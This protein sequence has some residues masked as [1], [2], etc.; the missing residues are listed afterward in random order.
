MDSRCVTGTSHRTGSQWPLR[1]AAPS[2]LIFPPQERGQ[3]QQ[4]REEQQQ[5]HQGEAQTQLPPQSSHQAEGEGEEP[6]TSKGQ[7]SGCSREE[8]MCQ[9]PPA[10]TRNL[11]EPLQLPTVQQ[12]LSEFC[13]PEGA[14]EGHPLVRWQPGPVQECRH[15]DLAEGGS[16]AST[17]PDGNGAATRTSH[18]SDG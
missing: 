5:G 2:S 15:D 13:V 16:T 18:R 8:G 14:P 11:L 10:S 17:Q 4:D 12:T 7:R 9:R 6:S 1:P 3:C